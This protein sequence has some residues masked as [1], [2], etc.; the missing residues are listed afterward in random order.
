MATS[1]FGRERTAT[2]AAKKLGQSPGT[3]KLVAMLIRGFTF[4]IFLF[5]V[6]PAVAQQQI[7][8]REPLIVEPEWIRPPRVV[9]PISA[10]ERGVDQAT[11][12]M[13]CTVLTNGRLTDCDVVAATSGL[14]SFREAALAG[15]SRAI[16]RP[17]IVEGRPE[18]TSVTFEL[19]FRV[20]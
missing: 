16:V 13:R 12:V 5:T 2:D 20:E 6:L 10:Q 18:V 7:S 4:C 3:A 17:A 8:P 9:F 14:R 15:V 19:R 11:L 1:A